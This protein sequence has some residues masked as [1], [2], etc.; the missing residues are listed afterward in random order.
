MDLAQQ[1]GAT[2]LLETAHAQSILAGA[3]PRRVALTGIEALTPSEHRAAEMAAEGMTNKEIAQAL[4][5]TLRSVEM[6]LS[7]AYLKLQITSRRGL[8]RALHDR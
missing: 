7:N 6:H 3:R 1:C 5:V 4:F 8:P 2:A